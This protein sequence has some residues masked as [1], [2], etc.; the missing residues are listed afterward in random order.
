MC[1][2][3]FFAAYNFP[4]IEIIEKFSR[5]LQS[6]SSLTMLIRHKI[7][8]IVVPLALSALIGTVS[9]S[10]IA[11]AVTDH[12]NRTVEVPDTIQHVAIADI[13]PY[14]SVTCVYLGS[15]NKIVAMHPTSMAA[16]KNSLL[17]KLYP[18]VTRINTNTMQGAEVNLEALMV[19]K[20]DVVFVNAG[21][22]RLIERL[23]AS[24]LPALAVSTSKWDY[25]VLE[26]YE[27]WIELLDQTFPDEGKAANALQKAR[28]IEKFVAQRTADIAPEKRRRVLFLVQYDGKRIITSGSR[29]FGQYW[30]AA[31]GSINVGQE[32][33][34]EK[35]N[36]VIDFERVLAWNPDAVFLTNF[37]KS[38]PQDILHGKYHNWSGIKAF[39]TKSV[40]K[41]PLGLYRS[42]TPSADSPL[43]LLWLACTLYPERFADFELEHEV[44]RF[45]KDV[46]GIDL[47]IEK[48]R[49]LFPLAYK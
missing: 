38:Q 15:C 23:E 8:S 10:A 47:T 5:H 41:M 6:V 22:K 3:H 13:F 12:L 32:L 46:Y 45:Y 49:E 16:A 1:P 25:D 39:E 20:P 29:F 36:A 40:Y 33:N 48:A 4:L 42:Y 26:T 11:R 7:F 30:A 31:S 27:N 28:E 14:A 2:L 17:G 9:G 44:Q 24:G 19:L 18:E 35:G 43:T 21:N 37:T 34:L